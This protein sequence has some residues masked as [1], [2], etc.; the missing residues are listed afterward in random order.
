[1]KTLIAI[2]FLALV[3]CTALADDAVKPVC[4]TALNTTLPQAWGDWTTP[5]TVPAAAT[6]ATQPEI[7]LGRAYNAPLKATASVDYA[8]P[9]KNTKE[10]TFG[11]LLMLTIEKAGIYAVAL[12]QPARIDVVRDGKIIKSSGH[13]HGPA[14]STIRK[15]VDF[16]L[17]PGHYTVQI[18]NA[19]KDTAL[20]EVII[21][22]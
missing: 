6:P 18:S 4:S 2:A 22:P 21:K 1:M 19:P 9:V 17:D 16:K 13:G 14:C 5:E 3:P 10:G 20:I 8:A 11:G 12:D 7:L 15:M